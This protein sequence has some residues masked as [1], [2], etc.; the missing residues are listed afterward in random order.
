MLSPKH[1][2]FPVTTIIAEYNTSITIFVMQL[3]MKHYSNTPAQIV[4]RN[5]FYL[6]ILFTFVC[7]L[8]SF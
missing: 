5:L 4:T 7:F 6:P 2:C 1:K 8:F 3:K